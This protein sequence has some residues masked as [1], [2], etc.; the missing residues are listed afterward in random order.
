MEKYSFQKGINQ[1]QSGRKQL[2]R[3]RIMT[4]LNLTTL[5]SYYQRLNG[6]V[7]PKVS[8]A[9]LIEEIFAKEGIKQ[10]W[11]EGEKIPVE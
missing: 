4:A 2:V 7:E 1:V 10:V 6:V 11:G 5:P 9:K 3:G 8:E